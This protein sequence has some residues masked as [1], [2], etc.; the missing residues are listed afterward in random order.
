MSIRTSQVPLEWKSAKISLVPKD[1]NLTGINNFR[2]IA[3][4]PTVS[5]IMEHLIQSQTMKYL[6]DNGILDVNQ[7][8][9]R[10]NNSTTAT[11]S[12]MLYDIYTNINNQQL[13]YSIFID[14][15]KAFDSINH[16]ILLRILKKLGF[17][18]SAV[19]WFRNYLT[20]RTQSTVVNGLK[21][22]LLDVDCRVPQGSVLGPMLFLLFI[23][24][25]NSCIKHSAY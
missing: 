16:E 23:N 9:F 14:F 20:D 6:E 19:D 2:P 1:G 25:L 24:D 4:L 15:R 17:N 13:T 10:K 5:K 8:G 7:G 11:T 21:S 18:E 12:A 22:S 3:I